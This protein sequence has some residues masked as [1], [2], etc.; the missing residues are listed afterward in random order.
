MLKKNWENIWES[1]SEYIKYAYL[2]VFKA[3]KEHSFVLESKQWG[4]AKQD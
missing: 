3:E 4:D 1:I 2:K